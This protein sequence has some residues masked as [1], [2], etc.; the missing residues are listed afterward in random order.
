MGMLAP[1]SMIALRDDCIQ[2]MSFFQ[3]V[4]LD[5]SLEI[6]SQVKT[7]VK[8]QQRL[9]PELSDNRPDCSEIHARFSKALLPR[10]WELARHTLK[11]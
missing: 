6:I 7:K 5:A 8:H 9:S 4:G 1:R 10:A 3:T 11:T 2:K